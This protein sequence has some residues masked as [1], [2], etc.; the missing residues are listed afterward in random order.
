MNLCSKILDA[1]IPNSFN[2]L[3]FLGKFD[4]IVCPHLREMLDLPLRGWVSMVPCSFWWGYLWY[5]VPSGWV[6]GKGMCMFKGVGTHPLDTWTWDTEG[7][8]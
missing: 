7:Y 5:H 3:Q 1:P 2:F 4:N 8:G 6:S